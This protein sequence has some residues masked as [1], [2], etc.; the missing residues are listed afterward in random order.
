ME[1]YLQ[2][3]SVL[4]QSFQPHEAHIPFILQFMMDY[5]L[6]GMSMINLSSVKYRRRIT[7][8]HSEFKSSNAG[9]SNS[10]NSSGGVATTGGI[11]TPVDEL[12][13]LPACVER[14]SICELE[15]DGLVSDILNR[16]DLERGIELNPGLAAIWEE[17]RARRA[18]AGL[19]CEDSQLVN[20]KSPG[21]PPY[22]LTDNDLYQQQRFNR[23]LYM[24]SQCDESTLSSASSPSSS[25]SPASLNQSS[26]PIETLNDDQLMNASNLPSL[27]S[28]NLNL[29]Q[30]IN[31]ISSLNSNKLSQESKTS[32][33]TNETSIC[34][35]STY[36]FIYFFNLSRK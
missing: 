15:V 33:L 26:Y 8:S 7:Q 28:Q 20:P 32:Q 16:Q 1:Y 17:E 19:A 4:N 9:S 31:E 30:H 27:N 13:Y 34:K 14:Q 18:Q 25:Y 21:R 11:I 12:D 6:H 23:R 35:Y 10:S 5:N 2:N 22:C 3:G 29:T 24:V 36:L